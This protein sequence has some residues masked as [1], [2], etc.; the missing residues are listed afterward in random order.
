[1]VCCRLNSTQLHFKYLHITHVIKHL[2]FELN[3]IFL[4]GNKK[5]ECVIPIANMSVSLQEGGVPAVLL[6]S[7]HT[8]ME[9]KLVLSV[10]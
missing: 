6:C 9:S 8:C 5:A 2:S 3:S 10:D 1:M 7:E 4:S